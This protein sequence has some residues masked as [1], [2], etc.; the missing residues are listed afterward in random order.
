MGFMGLFENLIVAPDGAPQWYYS[1]LK[2]S[3]KEFTKT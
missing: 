2:P 3:Q 1:I